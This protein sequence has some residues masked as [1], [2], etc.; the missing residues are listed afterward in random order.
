MNYK[1]K[2]KN[3][4]TVVLDVDGVLTHGANFNKHAFGVH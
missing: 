1:E 2:F 3:I 4:T